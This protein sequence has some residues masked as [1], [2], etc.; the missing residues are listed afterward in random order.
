M[1]SCTYSRDYV[2]N[3]CMDVCMFD[4]SIIMQK[5]WNIH[6]DV[7]EVSKMAAWRQNGAGKT[8]WRREDRMTPIHVYLTNIG[9]NFVSLLQSNSFGKSTPVWP[10]LYALAERRQAL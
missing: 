5:V 2:G 8:K 10:V 3:K 1:K 4:S 6:N 9:T 7:A